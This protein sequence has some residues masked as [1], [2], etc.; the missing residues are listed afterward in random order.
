VEGM[1]VVGAVNESL[2]R[3][4]TSVTVTGFTFVEIIFEAFSAPRDNEGR[5]FTAVMSLQAM[6][7]T[8]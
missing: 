5:G 1:H 8:A 2:H 7:D 6:L 4:E 3:Q